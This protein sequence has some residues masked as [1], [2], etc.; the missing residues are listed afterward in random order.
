MAKCL[1]VLLFG[2]SILLLFVCVSCHIV[3]LS[4]QNSDLAGL[5][6]FQKEKKYLQPFCYY[7]W[8]YHYFTLGIQQVIFLLLSNSVIFQFYR[9]TYSDL[10]WK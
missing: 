5:L 9:I 4:D 1:F 3:V 2:F 10:E 6:P 8:G 7:Y